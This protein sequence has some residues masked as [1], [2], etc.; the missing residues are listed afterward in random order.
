[1]HAATGLTLLAFVT[2]ARIHEPET[3][4]TSMDELGDML[5][6]K[7]VDRAIAPLFPHQQQLEKITLGKPG[8]FAMQ[9]PQ[10]SP[11]AALPP[12]T[13][14]APFPQR[15]QFKSFSNPTGFGSKGDEDH[16][17]SRRMALTSPVWLATA[18]TAPVQAADTTKTLTLKQIGSPAK[19]LQDQ[20]YNLIADKI[21]NGEL[22]ISIPDMMRLVLHDAITYDPE[23]KTG[24]FGGSIRFSE[25][26]G[27]PENA[28]LSPVVK[29]LE[30]LQK[31]VQE[32][33]GQ[34]IT[35][36]D[37]EAYTGQLLL[38]SDFKDTLCARK[39]TAPCAA[40]YAGYGNKP[41]R[42]LLGRPD[43]SGPD[44]EGR[45]PWVGSSVDD[46]KA[47]FKRLRMSPKD[48]TVLAPGLFAEEAK[49]YEFL[50][51]D[52]QCAGYLADFEKSKQSVTRNN[53]EISFFEAYTKLVN[54]ARIDSKAYGLGT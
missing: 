38:A 1:M 15:R 42:L 32:K 21:T 34:K 13:R 45:V 6:D 44:P 7:L 29:K 39:M 52:K 2:Q 30:A 23:T 28:G 3:S 35:F 40:M 27:R 16:E 50:M 46:F 33:T 18:L 8:H 24:G 25:E 22:G 19:E 4:G 11:L 53:Y 54:R 10:T 43:A 48:L 37:V 49:G 5:V 36:A 31:E 9:T 14:N 17:I 20:I 12:S 51:Q 41:E 47:A 26:L